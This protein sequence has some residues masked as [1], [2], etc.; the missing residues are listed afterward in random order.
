MKRPLKD[1]SPPRAAARTRTAAP[2]RTAI[3]ACAAAVIGVAAVIC[4]LAVWGNR[5]TF[6]V[7][8]SAPAP[9]ESPYDWTNLERDAERL[10]YAEDGQ[11]RSRSGIDVSEHQGVIDWQAV[12]ADGIDFAFVRVG[13]RGYTEG[14]LYADARC[15]ENLDGADAAGLAVGA[16]FFSQATDADEAREEAD[17]VVGLLAGRRLDLP[18]AFDHEPVPD[19][20]GRANGLSGQALADCAAAFCER[21]EEAGYDTM[22]YGNKNDM[23]RLCAIDGTQE[24]ADG[25]NETLGGRP[26]WFAEYDA[27]APS[28]QFD[29]AIWQYTNTGSVAG[30]ATPVDLDVLL[31]A[32]P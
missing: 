5:D 18:V 26:I 16:Y 24:A 1:A 7:E 20:A 17:F 8:K 13:N 2:A 27:A 10:A 21:L 32:A 12:A 31:P 9:Y 23:A 28:A 22:V 25:L 11:T 29:F 6:S 30:I 19:G 4:I 14:A 3:A 15:A